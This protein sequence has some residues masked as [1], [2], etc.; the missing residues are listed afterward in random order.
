M[1]VRCIPLL[2]RFLPLALVAMP[3]AGMT[4]LS[5]VPSVAQTLDDVFTVERV[6]ADVTAASAAVAREQG[7][8]QAQRDAFARLFDR[9]TLDEDGARLPALGAAEIEQMVDSFEVVSERSSSVRYVAEINVSFRP[10]AVRSLMLSNGI[11]Y[12][13]V[14]SKPVLILPVDETGQEPVLW[15]RETPWR[16]AWENFSAPPSLL[17]ILVPY[18]EIQDVTDID[19][20]EALAGNEE[21][22]RRIAD[23]YGAGAV[24]VARLGLDGEL[25]PP[26]PPQDPF[27]PADPTSFLASPGSAMTS[28]DQAAEEV[29]SEGGAE[30]TDRPR[31]LM[32]IVTIHRF[33]GQPEVLTVELPPSAALPE[34]GAVTVGVEPAA[35]G[36]EPAAGF[37]EE[38]PEDG[39]GAVPPEAAQLVPAAVT[40]VAAALEQN[41][42]RANLLETGN[43]S[44]LSVRV[45]LSSLKEWMETRSRLAQVPTVTRTRLIELSRDQAD[46][47]LYYL[48]DS[49]GLRTALA[50]RDLLLSEPPPA[51]V[52]QMPLSGAMPPQAE[53][54]W[55][56]QWRGA[57]A[58]QPQPAVYG[59][60]VPADMGGTGTLPPGTP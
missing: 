17:P 59:T 38:L 9:L 49:N 32:S 18:G 19:V 3:L 47:E 14:R 2:R 26:P 50:Q 51:F 58:V 8:A 25:Q 54:R 60:P 7:I 53:P 40:Q 1:L 52:G 45:P 31:G 13:E 12:A 24:A 37:S 30:D 23:R 41:W 42:I 4:A 36:E 11:R 15:Q 22:M 35:T 29:P 5:P 46:I 34:D 20:N 39:A 56:L 44:V 21:A 33:Q 6:P 28:P 48:G 55:Q 43:E 10:A 16:Q 57:A 27:A